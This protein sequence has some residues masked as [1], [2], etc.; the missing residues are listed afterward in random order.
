MSASAQRHRL[1]QLQFWDLSWEGTSA[2]RFRDQ[3]RNGKLSK[4]RLAQALSRPA[5]VQSSSEKDPEFDTGD[6]HK[7]GAGLRIGQGRGLEQARRNGRSRFQSRVAGI[8][9]S[10]AKRLRQRHE[11]RVLGRRLTQQASLGRRQRNR[12]LAPPDSLKNREKF[13]AFLGLADS[14]WLMTRGGF[15]GEEDRKKLIALARVATFYH[16]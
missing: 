6:C 3:F 9:P 11:F 15:L 2:F 1:E 7:R 10:L 13:L 8:G 16:R 5:G 4:G 14:D 12:Q